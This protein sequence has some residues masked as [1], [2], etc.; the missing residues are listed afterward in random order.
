MR[1]TPSVNAVSS[2]NSCLHDGGRLVAAW[3]YRVLKENEPQRAASAV[4][5]IEGVRSLW[6]RKK[7]WGL[8]RCLGKPS[9]PT[10]TCDNT[11]CRKGGD[12]LTRWKRCR[13]LSRFVICPFL[14]PPPLLLPLRYVPH[15]LQQCW[16]RS[17][18][19]LP[20]KMR[21]C[22]HVS[23]QL[24][25]CCVFSGFAAAPSLS[26]RCTSRSRCPTLRPCLAAE[27]SSASP[28]SLPWWVG[29]VQT[30][31]IKGK[32]FVKEPRTA[33]SG[34]RVPARRILKACSLPLAAIIMVPEKPRSLNWLGVFSK[35]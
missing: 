10:T 35:W 7:F 34:T 6:R 30:R 13:R 31:D 33:R 16:C 3:S 17:V 18:V 11:P 32:R 14:V 8:R 24:T 29:R 2:T 12:Q 9:T 20:S 1:I 21:N 26:R 28:E 15:E 22:P 4:W 25:T 27:Y 5:Q 19:T 23:I